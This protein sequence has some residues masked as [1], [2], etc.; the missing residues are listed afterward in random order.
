MRNRNTNSSG[1]SWS[2]SEI[3]SV[4]RTASPYGSYN[5]KQDKCGSYMEFSKYGKTELYGWEIDHIKPVAKGGTD[6]LS[7]LQPLFWEN[8]RRKGD[9]YPWSCK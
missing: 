4:W 9:T 6:D 8:N 1:G 2:Q 7:N 3:D 5:Y